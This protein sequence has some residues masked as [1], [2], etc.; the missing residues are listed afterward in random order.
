MEVI[1]HGGIAVALVTIKPLALG[2]VH[3]VDKLVEG[4]RV[5]RHG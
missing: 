5:I 2:R 3:G 1:L 4:P